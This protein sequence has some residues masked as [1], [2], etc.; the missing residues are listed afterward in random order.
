[1]SVYALLLGMVLFVAALVAHVL[2][3]RLTS[4]KREIFWLFGIFLVCPLLLVAVG[5]GNGYVD[6]REA[7]AISLVQLSLA[8]VYIQTYPALKSDIPTFRILLLLKQHTGRGL[9]DQ[10]IIQMM[11]PARLFDD[12]LVELE[13]DS[14][15][16][17]KDGKLQLSLAGK[18]IA[19][20]FSCYRS[21]LGLK[22]GSG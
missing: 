5:T 1:M 9:T 22:T 7:V 16:L 4:V 19:A 20:V 2:V 15:I 21:L 12:K 8:V 6:L 11:A 14:L 18:V 10:E 13:G 3:W 17:L